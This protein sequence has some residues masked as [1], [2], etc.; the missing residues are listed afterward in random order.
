[1]HFDPGN[2]LHHH[3]AENTQ[4]RDGWKLAPSRRLLLALAA[5]LAVSMTPPTFA[6]PL[7]GVPCSTVYLAVALAVGVAAVV[8][9]VS[10]GYLA[11]RLV[12]FA[13]LLALVAASVPLSHGLQT[14]WFAM[15]AVWIKGLVCFTAMLVLAWSTTAEELLRALRQLYIPVLFVATLLFMYRYLHVAADEL[16]RMRRAR[17]ARTF[18]QAPRARLRTAA[19]L[20]GMLLVR[21]FER[22][23]RVHAAMLARG[24]DGEIRSLD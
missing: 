19:G 12:I 15:G 3:P 4:R 1:M 9:R 23:E 7:P 2:R 6:A 14:G 10:A 11:S 20:I 21:S 16:A 24:F 18:E 13:P 5:V 22:S 8:A 17:A